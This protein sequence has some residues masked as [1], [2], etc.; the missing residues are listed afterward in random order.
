MEG[1]R[2]ICADKRRRAV[3]DIGV[4][5]SVSTNWYSPAVDLALPSWQGE[6]GCRGAGIHN[7]EWYWVRPGVYSPRAAYC[8][9][10]FFVGCWCCLLLFS[11]LLPGVPTAAPDT[12]DQGALCFHQL[13][14]YQ[15]GKIRR[16]KVRLESHTRKEF[17][18]QYAWRP[19]RERCMFC[20]TL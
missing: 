13:R 3:R 8:F 17:P 6:E 16:K 11:T 19:G 20:S 18:P 2:W 12:Y 10:Q 4:C 5:T 7:E 14:S 9:C 1:H 15:L